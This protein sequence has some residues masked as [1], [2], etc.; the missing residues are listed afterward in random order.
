MRTD[1]LLTVDSRQISIREAF[2]RHA[3]V[4][5][6]QF[7]CR[8][9]ARQIREEVWRIADSA[10]SA[11]RQILDLGCGTGEDAIHYAKLGKHVTAVDLAPQM[12][13][14]LAAKIERAGVV[15][16]VESAVSAMDQ[17]QS[18]REFDGLISNL[19]ALNCL[20]DLVWMRTF[21]KKALE[22]GTPVVLTTM[23]RW[24]PLE[25]LVFLLKG[26]FAQLALTIP[27]SM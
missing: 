26:D 21:A 11:S 4:Y 19:G 6:E 10:F 25:T 27:A 23:G 3:S 9:I 22:T 16:Q 20:P 5:D 18:P 17:F 24:Y 13:S 12:I 8:A 1:T 15:A 14:R 7:S 2:D